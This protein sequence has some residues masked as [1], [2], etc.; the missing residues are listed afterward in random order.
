[1]ES[2]L[3]RPQATAFRADAYPDLDGKAAAL[4][5]SLA[6]NHA[7]VDGNKRL[8]LAGA[9]AFCGINGRRLTLTN[10]RPT[11]WSSPSP[12]GRLAPSTRSPP[13]WP[14]PLSHGD[15]AT[16]GIEFDSGPGR[17]ARPSE[18]SHSARRTPVSLGVRCSVTISVR[19]SRIRLCAMQNCE[20]DSN[21]QATS[22]QSARLVAVEPH[23]ADTACP[24]RRRPR[25][26]YRAGL[27][28]REHRRH[29]GPRR[30]ERR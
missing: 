18:C 3:A 10:D 26:L 27:H 25:G 15:H 6:S 28:E 16:R 14:V 13:G 30:I 20:A 17:A 7:L 12:T 24:A 4:L 21:G 29:R 5:H 2:A 11:T 9:I 1:M 19:L 23:G 8:A 22:Q